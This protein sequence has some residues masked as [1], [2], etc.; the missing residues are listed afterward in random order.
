MKKRLKKILY[1]FISPIRKFYWFIFNP[2]TYGVK[3]LIGHEGKFLMIRNSYGIKHWTFPGGGKKRN[4]TPEAGAKREILE[5]VGMS[6][7]NLVYL[8][9]YSS[10]RQYKKDTVY[11]FYGKAENNQYRIDNDEVEEAGWFELKDV[12]EFHSAAVDD[13]LNLFRERKLDIVHDPQ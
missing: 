4:E 12:P 7:R 3:I 5:E 2:K 1:R 8:G 13:V 10:R 9:T 11:C 6:L